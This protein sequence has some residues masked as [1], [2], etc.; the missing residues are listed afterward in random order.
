MTVQQ[1]IRGLR[2]L[3]ERLVGSSYIRVI[4]LLIAYLHVQRSASRDMG[5]GFK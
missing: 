1:P 5:D 3:R 2:I 4:D